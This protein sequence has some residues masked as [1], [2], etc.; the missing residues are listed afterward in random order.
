MEPAVVSTTSYEAKAFDM[1]MPLRI[2]AQKLPDAVVLPV[3]QEAY[4]A[5]SGTVVATL[6][7]QPGATVQVLGCAALR[8]LRWSWLARSP[9]RGGSQRLTCRR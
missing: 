3:D 6:R 7:E 4:L 2:A 8:L 1:E 5:G 9:L